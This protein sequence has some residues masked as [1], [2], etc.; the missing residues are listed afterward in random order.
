MSAQE[1]DSAI[2]GGFA[3]NKINNQYSQALDDDCIASPPRS[4]EN[5]IATI[6]I[7]DQLTVQ[8]ERLRIQ[9][10][11]NSPAEGLQGLSAE[12]L[13]DIADV[14]L[15]EATRAIKEWTHI[16]ITSH[17][18]RSLLLLKKSNRN[19]RVRVDLDQQTIKFRSDHLNRR[20]LKRMGFN[21]VRKDSP[22][23]RL[24][25]SE[26]GI[27]TATR[28]ATVRLK[29]IVSVLTPEQVAKWR[30]KRGQQGRLLGLELKFKR[31][32]LRIL[33]HDEC[34]YRRW[35]RGLLYAQQTATIGF[36]DDVTGNPHHVHL[37]RMY[38]NA[39]GDGSNQLTISEL[40]RE[41]NKYPYYHFDADVVAQLHEKADHAGAGCIQKHQFF[42]VAESLLT[43]DSIKAE[44]NRIISH[45]ADY[46][47]SEN[48]QPLIT[49][50]MLENWLAVNQRESEAIVEEILTEHLNSRRIMSSQEN[51]IFDREV[52]PF[53]EW[54]DPSPEFP[55][56]EMA[57]TLFGFSRLIF[58]RHA[59]VNLN[60]NSLYREPTGD[61]N[62]PI[63]RYWI[64]GSFNTFMT[65]RFNDAANLSQES[66]HCKVDQSSMTRAYRVADSR[67]LLVQY[68]KAISMGVK[69][70]DIEVWD[71]PTCYKKVMVDKGDGNRPGKLRH[72][73]QKKKMAWAKEKPTPVV[74][75]NSSSFS[76]VSL[77]TLLQ[78]IKQFTFKP[79]RQVLDERRN[80]ARRSPFEPV[81]LSL[82]TR[83]P[84]IL[85]FDI[86]TSPTVTAMVGDVISEVLG[87][88]LFKGISKDTVIT[89][90]KATGKFLIMAKDF[91]LAPYN[92]DQ[93][94]SECD[95]RFK[96]HT[97]RMLQ[98]ERGVHNFNATYLP[99]KEQ[100]RLE[101]EKVQSDFG[102]IHK[103]RP[104]L[105]PAEQ[106]IEA[107]ELAFKELHRLYELHK[108]GQ[109][110]APA[111][112]TQSPFSLPTEQY[113]LKEIG[114]LSRDPML[115]SPKSMK[116]MKSLGGGNSFR[117]LLFNDK[118]VI[119]SIEL[120]DDTAEGI[121]SARQD[122]SNRFRLGKFY[123][124]VNMHIIPFAF[125][126]G[127][128]FPLVGS[129]EEEGGEG[130]L[131][132][133]VE[134]AESSKLAWCENS[135]LSG[136]SRA[137]HSLWERLGDNEVL[138]H[139][140]LKYDR[141]KL[142]WNSL[143]LVHPDGLRGTS[144]NI[145]PLPLWNDGVSIVSS[146]MFVE[147][148]TKNVT[149]ARF[150]ANGGCGYV[151]KP[152]FY[153]SSLHE[154][155][156][157]CREEWDITIQLHE[158]RMLPR[159]ATSYNVL[160]GYHRRIRQ[161]ELDTRPG[162]E[163]VSANLDVTAPLFG[164][165]PNDLEKLSLDSSATLNTANLRVQAVKRNRR[166][167]VSQ[168]LDYL[169]N[170]M[171]GPQQ[172]ND[173][174]SHHNSVDEKKD[175]QPFRGFVPNS[176][177]PVKDVMA[178]DLNETIEELG[179]Q[180][181]TGTNPYVVMSVVGDVGGPTLMES[182][183]EI[184]C[185][186][187][188]SWGDQ[189]PFKVTVKRRESAILM[190]ELR[191]YDDVASELLGSY[192]VPMNALGNGLRNIP[193]R[194]R[195]G[196][197]IN[198]ACLIVT[199]DQIVQQTP[200]LKVLPSMW[201][202]TTRLTV[203]GNSEAQSRIEK[204]SKR[205][206]LSS[207]RPRRHS[208]GSSRRSG[209]ANQNKLMVESTSE[210]AHRSIVDK[211]KLRSIATKVWGSP[212][213]QSGMSPSGSPNLW[214][215][216]NKGQTLGFGLSDD[217]TTLVPKLSDKNSNRG[218]SRLTSFMGTPKMASKGSNESDGNGVKRRFR[219]YKNRRRSI[220]PKAGSMGEPSP[221][222]DAEAVAF[223][224]VDAE[225]DDVEG[226]VV[227]GDD[228]EGDVVDQVDGKDHQEKSE[229]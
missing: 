42:S 10:N 196:H 89:P 95:Q 162:T 35:I 213:G 154:D 152:E 12:I 107:Q 147:G 45:A 188:A 189:P 62:L 203:G 1:S 204:R 90:E 100:R 86:Q 63:S 193:L 9:Q 148:M 149:L 19:A 121:E 195:N 223:E 33:F 112:S 26:D 15:Q 7:A 164:Q 11:I 143:W 202:T 29:D 217:S 105:S 166:F 25:G 91:R 74:F 127:T 3:K 135:I 173:S 53:Y 85:K 114:L 58:S 79:T 180:P 206:S 34:V 61:M 225:G 133:N 46:G 83:F 49:R 60:L 20:A 194:D 186:A 199:V 123:D 4:A 201:S 227:E 140:Y 14:T 50:S 220:S 221:L 175:V 39:D 75:C 21:E 6:T 77:R 99:D 113:I 184:D 37:A 205:E 167:S 68:E 109:S 159:P 106:E 44:F 64:M 132:V 66:R 93:S 200:D 8:Q 163:E 192:S 122:V 101:G 57:L 228:V 170:N 197:A 158:G 115:T 104:D 209:D 22:Q 226:D 151:P 24:D 172:S 55:E 47:V 215:P 54:T 97:H 81:F 229:Y 178:N 70:L 28:T 38:E 134:S 131:H 182:R 48:S 224:Q 52:V 169:L 32:G 136:S 56:G 183:Y 210:E 67:R 153:A 5:R 78:N 198:R 17:R 108:S 144:L 65:G 40:F 103:K 190:I 30:Q 174:L 96:G 126:D 125:Q 216:G 120:L 41:L 84:I 119:P 87:D 128:S 171:R 13:G 51:R 117:S 129:A 142:S 23:R 137:F 98:M 157:E 185:G 59:C 139:R 207:H 71:S 222:T 187:L 211:M 72:S 76:F 212:G 156:Y 118:H 155:D 141:R 130:H 80:T 160:K 102:K 138:P 218:V 146:N 177:V 94:Q 124:L 161:S 73:S 219:S 168:N 191:H 88:Y 31:R 27:Y 2:L 43:T 116:T 110:L 208:R 82:M 181:I 69:C 111:A 145:N 18:P 179:M 36:T 16:E 165:G 92:F 176:A 214:S 150:S